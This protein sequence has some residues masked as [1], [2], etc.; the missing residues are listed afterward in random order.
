MKS[1]RCTAENLKKK[2]NLL[3]FCHQ[4]VIKRHKKCHS[5]GTGVMSCFKLCKKKKGMFKGS[6]YNNSYKIF[7]ASIQVLVLVSILNT[8]LALEVKFK[9]IQSIIYKLHQ[10]ELMNF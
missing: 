7:S 10:S 5:Y 8:V 9:A 4:I 3:L 2:K 6:S 1:K